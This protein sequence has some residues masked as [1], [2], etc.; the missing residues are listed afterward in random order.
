MDYEYYST[1]PAP[2]P[3][4]SEINAEMLYIP[5]DIEIYRAF[6]QFHRYRNWSNEQLKRRVDEWRAVAHYFM[7]EQDRKK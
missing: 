3:T 4:I 7:R 1:E 2:E 6:R 5:D